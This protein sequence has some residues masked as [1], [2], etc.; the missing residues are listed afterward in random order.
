[1]RKPI[2]ILLSLSYIAVGL[3]VMS[4]VLDN[5]FLGDDL[6]WLAQAKGSKSLLTMIGASPWDGYFRPTFHALIWLEWKLFRTSAIGYHGV[7][8]FI[9]IACGVLLT[10]LVFLT[11]KDTW[12]S[13]LSGITFLFLSIGSEAVYWISAQNVL[14]AVCLIEAVL[15]VVILSKGRGPGYLILSGVVLFVLAL[16]ALVVAAAGLACVLWVTLRRRRYPAGFIFLLLTA[17]YIITYRSLSPELSGRVLEFEQ[18]TSFF[19]SYLRS[20]LEAYARTADP[21]G[22]KWIAGIGLAIAASVVGWQIRSARPLHWIITVAL[23]PYVLALMRHPI[24]SSTFP[25]DRYFYVA[26]PGLSV[27]MALLLVR[28]CTAARL[29]SNKTIAVVLGVVILLFW[30]SPHV[31]VSR[32]MELLYEEP[33]LR[34]ENVIRE[35]QGV[36]PGRPVRLVLKGFAV[37]EC[38]LIPKVGTLFFRG[39]LRCDRSDSESKIIVE[40]D[41]DGSL[42]WHKPSTPDSTVQYG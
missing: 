14:L 21:V 29:R 16:G 3:A 19:E 28:F 9:H 23:F 37:P 7:S 25:F 10:V 2:I 38:W 13:F 1:M 32:K 41:R 42:R 4:P 27:L 40:R 36:D 34:L 22:G 15:V 30:A 26:R 33:S 39:R 8:V 35:V 17:G 24:Q 11:T 5:W 20:V 31:R 6:A 18:A 12:L